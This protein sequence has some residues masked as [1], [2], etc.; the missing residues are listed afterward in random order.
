[1]HNYNG[2]HAFM[3][4]MPSYHMAHELPAERRALPVLKVLHRNT[5]FI[6]SVGGRDHEAMH[7]VEPA[8]LSAGQPGGEQLREATRHADQDTA[9]RTLAALARGPLADAYNALQLIVEDDIDVHRVV[10]AWRAWATLDLTGR[11]QAL[12]LLRQSVR[13]CVDSEKSIKEHK[14]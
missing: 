11:E 4:L 7:P 14:R 6:Q 9:E 13:F 12:T 2:Y 8:S 5:R 10:L 1:G 3:A